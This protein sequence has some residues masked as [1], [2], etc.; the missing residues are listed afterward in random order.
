MTVNSILQKAIVQKQKEKLSLLKEI[1]RL[2]KSA[3]KTKSDA[4]PDILQGALEVAKKISKR[5]KEEP[6]N[7]E[8]CNDSCELNIRLVEVFKTLGRCH[9]E[10]SPQIVDKLQEMHQL[11]KRTE[12]HR[13]LRT[14][15]EAYNETPL[16][17]KGQKMPDAERK[18]VQIMSLCASTN[19]MTDL[20]FEMLE[21]TDRLSD[22]MSL[23]ASTDGAGITKQSKFARL[24]VE[25]ATTFICKKL[26]VTDWRNAQEKLKEV[27]QKLVL[28]DAGMAARLNPVNKKTEAKQ[29]YGA[30][31]D[32]LARNRNQK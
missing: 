4:L 28:L 15:L 30:V 9:K 31:V 17:A 6:Y 1:V 8:L 11:N 5:E 10:A 27:S 21:L 29:K 25:N 20:R 32:I 2:E 26:R 14:F 18:A 13:L 19:K 3:P 23:F 22:T 16:F 7:V 24:F 12:D